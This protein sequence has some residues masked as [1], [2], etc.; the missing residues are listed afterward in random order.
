MHIKVL[1]SAIYFAETIRP[2]IYLFIPG[3]EETPVFSLEYDYNKIY[4][5]P[6]YKY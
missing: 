3:V 1:L 6:K 4:N 5:H 2:A